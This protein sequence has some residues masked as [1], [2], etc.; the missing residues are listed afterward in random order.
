M[1][2]NGRK[3]KIPV[4]L[5]AALLF[6]ILIV[7]ARPV[8]AS[9]LTWYGEERLTSDPSAS[10]LSANG[11]RSVTCDTAGYI[12]VVWADY[13]TGTSS[14]YHKVYD[15]AAWSADSMISDPTAL[16]YNPAIDAD[17][18]GGVHVAWTDYRDGNAE[19]Y[20]RAFDGAV[21]G[22]EERLTTSS[23]TSL[24]PSI[25]TGSGG[26]VHIV[27]EDNR[28]GNWEIY[29]K[30]HDG[31]AWSA[32]ERL[33]DNTALSTGASVATDAPGNVYVVWQ[34]SRQGN[35]EIYLKRN[36]GIA[37]S[38]D[39]RV[40]A[41]GGSSENPTI[42]VDGGGTWH[43]V[44]DDDRGGAPQVYYKFYEGG[45]W[46]ADTVLSAS[47][48]EATAPTIQSDT[49]GNLHVVWQDTRDG[50]PD[51]YYKGFHNGV[52]ASDQPLTFT[53][54][55]SRKPSITVTA[56][57][58]VHVVWEDRRHGPGEI[59][60][61][62]SAG[63]QVD[64]L[65]VTSIDPSEGFFDALVSITDL[66]GENFLTPAEVRLEKAGEPDIVATDVVVVSPQKITCTFDL[67]GGVLGYWDV[68]VGNGDGQVATLPGGFEIIPWDPPVI[69]S[70][71]P[72]EGEYLE[73]VNVPNLLGHDFHPGADV[74]LLKAGEPD[75]VAS[76][77]VV[78]SLER[79]TCTIYLDG[80]PGHW[81][82]AVTNLDGGSDTLYSGFW[83]I[84]WAKPEISSI[85]PSQSSYL[86]TVDITDLAGDNFRPGA[87][88]RLEMAGEPDVI[89]TDV[90]VVSPTK[91]TCS[92][93][94]DCAAGHWD[95]VVENVDTQSDTLAAGFW[96]KAWAQ[97]VLTSITPSFGYTGEFANITDLAGDNFRTGMEVRL[98]MAGEPVIVA[99]D[100][101]IETPEKATCMFMLSG[102]TGL[103][104]VVVENL[105]GMADT[106]PSG[107]TV[108]PGLW[109]G[110]TRL[111]DDTDFSS[112]SK[113]NARCIA[114]DDEG[115]LHVVWQDDRDGNYEI[116]YK[117]YDGAWAPD[118]RLTA[119]SDKSEYPSVAVDTDGNVHVVWS[120]HRDGNAEIYYKRYD[121]V[122]GSDERL[123]NSAQGSLYPAI[124]SDGSNN[125][126]LVWQEYNGST[127]EIRYLNFDGA[128]W[129]NEELLAYGNYQDRRYPTLAV[130]EY[131]SV[132]VAWSVSTGYIEYKM[133]DGVDW[134]TTQ[135]LTDPNQPGAPSIAAGPGGRL[136]LIW[137]E[138][139]ATG[140]GYEVFEVF[141][142]HFD[143]AAWG[144]DEKITGDASHS[145]NATITIDDSANV[146][147][148]WM[149]GRHGDTELY[150]SM[151]DGTSWSAEN[152]LTG[153]ERESRFP[154]CCTD[155]EG[156]VHVVWSD[157]RDE[158]FEI[159]YKVRDPWPLAGLEEGLVSEKKPG[160]L[161]I[162]PNPVTG[163][164][165]IRFALERKAEVG[166]SV[167]D[168][169]G[170]LVWRASHK[171]LGPGTHS[172]RWDGLDRAGRSVAPGVYFFLLQAGRRQASS[173]VVVLR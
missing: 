131:D 102:G 61:R 101:V 103:W 42:D 51:I 39:R 108:L 64:L 48:G 60:W 94:L 143:G 132:H 15:G 28:D 84:P 159:Y 144:P 32:D 41:D 21:W 109:S 120:D 93:Y 74:R 62:W 104:D 118:E 87:E 171:G 72:S 70:I 43:V 31:L 99:T 152:R 30:T 73:T 153:A 138:K 34:D 18:A 111:T 82:V 158:N 20:Y 52:W 170:R 139:L 69:T 19:I 35:N 125:L 106:L 68:T 167:F 169:A 117:R 65:V 13:R 10:N 133:F 127:Y 163:E 8:S 91:I 2:T 112:T 164:A 54:E 134:G 166:I 63:D 80:T 142:K 45:A 146:Y 165:R 7:C 160:V 107:F 95:V 124:A 5:H 22:A 172:F 122:W 116:Y 55:E 151:F 92:F 56:S 173:K 23:D 81:D 161:S 58:S 14:I 71:D 100:V 140:L 49:A 149:D 53:D 38:T 57:D 17:D 76:S 86:E 141:Y 156:R 128:A 121:G 162:A 26:S 9:W 110:D 12:H 83:L 37:W 168:T 150:Y 145:H 113:P 114:A 89:A 4:L 129:G 78:V 105:D 59:Y 79:I 24:D 77:V 40:T 96:V 115:N 98:E 29:Y 119:A 46:S 6:A 25:A 11:A 44:W 154:F 136:H 155:G 130:D 137:H 85:T 147:V 3:Q 50:D 88:V 157:R 90:D 135:I 148:V 75:I 67:A 47:A 66:A 123:T 33:T 27:W 16:A 97:P 36:D 126:H 1:K